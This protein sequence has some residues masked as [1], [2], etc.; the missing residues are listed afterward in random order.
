MGMSQSRVDKENKGHGGRNTR[1]G[2]GES[3]RNQTG[4]DRRGGEKKEEA[5][6]RERGK[7]RGNKRVFKKTQRGRTKKWVTT[8]GK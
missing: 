4:D 5:N 2:N 8:V 6:G 3:K 7:N 1:E